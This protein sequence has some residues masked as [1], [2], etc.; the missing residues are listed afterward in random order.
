MHS[1]PCIGPGSSYCVLPQVVWPRPQPRIM[2]AMVF[3]FI[4][5]SWIHMKSGLQLRLHLRL[6]P[7]LLPFL[8]GGTRAGRFVADITAHV[9]RTSAGAIVQTDSGTIMNVQ[10]VI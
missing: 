2:T 7:S 4:V 3:Q 5:S 9:L 1:T 6:F 10:L 8:N